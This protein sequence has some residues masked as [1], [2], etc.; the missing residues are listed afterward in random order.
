[1]STPTRHATM[2]DVAQAARV[3]QSTVSRI[4]SG[5]PPAV[6]ISPAT[7]ERV[8]A[9]AQRMQYRPNPLA[10]GLK[11]AATMLIG[12]IVRDVTDPFFAAAIDALSSH[13]REH[14]YSVVLG[15]ARGSADEAL[16]LAAV[17]EARQCD[18]IVLLGDIADEAQM[19]ADLESADVP[20][21]E[22][23]RG[24]GQ[25]GYPVIAVDNAGGMR[26][27]LE[28]LAGLGHEHVAFVGDPAKADVEQRRDG[29]LDW[30]GS[31]ADVIAATNTPR[32]G[33]RAL[34][35]LLTRGTP[36][37]AVAAAT[38]VLAFGVLH[39][40]ATLGLSVPGDLSVTGFDDI[41]LS[42]YAV[43]GLTTVR[44]PVAEM[45]AAAVQR[46]IAQPETGERPGP[47]AATRTF[48]TELVVRASTGAVR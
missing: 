33:A 6:P 2:K 37:T 9:T 34:D 24:S 38:D 21:V 1:V 31:R 46:A 10:R 15:H 8:L 28:H 42:E 35:Q 48:P 39:R 23:W 4:L 18:A 14:G 16:A 20:V 45:A 3:S 13:A 41:P 7:R 19:L 47:G 32:A 44:M 26:A 43:P 5:A 22:L 27:A 17:L 40:A 12:A 30:A 11:G 29:Y 36:P 25:G